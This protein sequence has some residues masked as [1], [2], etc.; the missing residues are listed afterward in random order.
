MM[1]MMMLF[2]VMISRIRLRTSYSAID[3]TYS[4]STFIYSYTEV[5]Y[6]L[7]SFN[8]LSRTLARTKCVLVVVVWW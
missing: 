4:T 2:R 5:A 6:L 7:I 3:N 8:Y 1:V